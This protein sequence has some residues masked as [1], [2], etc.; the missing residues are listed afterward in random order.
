MVFVAKYARARYR[1]FLHARADPMRSPDLI[2]GVPTPVYPRARKVFGGEGG[3]PPR[4]LHISHTYAR[5]VCASWS[6]AKP[7]P[8]SGFSRS[9]GARDGN[10]RTS[11]RTRVVGSI[12]R[13]EQTMKKPRCGAKTRRGTLC[14]ASAIWSVK[15]RRYTRCRNHGGMSTGPKTAEGIERC[16]K[17]NWKHGRF[18]KCP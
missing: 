15:R 11:T 3:F 10:F 1:V 9:T 13:R 5:G 17:A 4:G 6:L 18:A 12:Q 14:Q 8:N 16:R 2:G 7:D